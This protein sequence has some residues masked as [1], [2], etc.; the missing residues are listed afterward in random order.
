MLN[1]FARHC[2][3]IT[4]LLLMFH[5]FHRAPGLQCT[6]LGGSATGCMWWLDRGRMSSSV[7]G[8]PSLLQSFSYPLSLPPS[9]GQQ[10]WCP[11]TQAGTEYFLCSDKLLGVESISSDTHIL[12]W[13]LCPVGSIPSPLTGPR[14]L[15]APD[16]PAL[17][18]R[19]DSSTPAD[20]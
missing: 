13:P 18:P 15:G 20:G 1:S 2:I 17:W 14:S 11:S 12:T 5:T 8:F 6:C 19:P 7:S 4:S 10:A 3:D 9:T 16:L